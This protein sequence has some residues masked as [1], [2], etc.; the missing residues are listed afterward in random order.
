MLL[1]TLLLAFLTSLAGLSMV[2]GAFL[3]GR[4]WGLGVIAAL[5]VAVGLLVRSV[6]VGSDR[7]EDTEAID[8][9]EMVT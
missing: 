1:I 2:L 8:A 6:M 9:P 3:V 5:L 7:G 4:W